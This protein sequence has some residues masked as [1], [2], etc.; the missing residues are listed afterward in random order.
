MRYCLI[1]EAAVRKEAEA[2]YFS[3]GQKF[4]FE[5]AVQD[6]DGPVS[7]E[8]AVEDDWEGEEDDRLRASG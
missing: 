5:Q 4:L 1:N 6:E 8:A 3:R 7:I 2:Q